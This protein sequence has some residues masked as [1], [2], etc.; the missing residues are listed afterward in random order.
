M[1]PCRFG[2]DEGL[3]AQLPAAPG[4]GWRGA[5]RGG[6]ENAAQDGEHSRHELRRRSGTID[7]EVPLPLQLHILSAQ[8]PQA[9]ISMVTKLFDLVSMAFHVV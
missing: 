6:R 3:A 7:Q 2:G 9:S 4:R 8:E 1:I 5:G